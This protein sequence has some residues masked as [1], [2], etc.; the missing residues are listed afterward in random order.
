MMHGSQQAIA[1]G[2]IGCAHDRIIPNLGMF[3][4]YPGGKRNTI[5]VRY[6]DLQGMMEQRK[7]LIYKIGDPREFGRDIEG[8]VEVVNYMLP[9]IE[10]NEGDML[11]TDNCSAGG[12]G[13]PIERDPSW[14]KADL[15]KGLT[16]EEIASRI[17]CVSLNY[18]EK[19]KEWKV[20]QTATE[21]LRQARR[22]ERLARAVP[23][24]EWWGQNRK[25]IMLR[26]MHPMILE[27]YQSSMKMSEA[28]AKEY[29]DFWALPDDFVL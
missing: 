2:A 15:D 22:K 13:D 24:K 17:Y 20:D 6:R 11:V 26:D 19:A 28:F 3:G 16:T 25:R 21:K 4:G 9:P 12:L 27:M 23:V 18:D 1:S 10:V 14:V 7:P 29:R 5:L 8:E